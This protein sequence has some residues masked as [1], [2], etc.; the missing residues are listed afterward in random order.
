MKTD[1]TVLIGNEFWDLIGGQGTY[2][3]FI[4]EINNLGKEYRLRIYTEYLGIKPPEN[5][6]EEML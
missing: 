2:Q 3:L 5:F 4:K 6:N 1:K